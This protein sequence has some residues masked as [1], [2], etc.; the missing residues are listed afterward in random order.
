MAPAEGG[1]QRSEGAEGRST[2]QKVGQKVGKVLLLT[3]AGL[4]LVAV[5]GVAVLTNTPWGREQIRG[6]VL[7]QLDEVV[8]G[9]IEVGRLSGNLLRR[10][11]LRD[12]SLVD[13]QGRPF[14]EAEEVWIRYSITGLLRQRIILTGLHIENAR[15]V[16][17]DP[18]EEGWNFARIFLPDP[19]PDPEPEPG[20]GDWVELRE[21][22]IARTD[23]LIRMPWAPDQ[24][25]PQAE[26]EE[27]IRQALA[28]ETRERLVEVPGGYQ[29]IMEFRE[30]NA[31]LPRILVAH[32]D[33]ADTAVEVAELSVTALPFHPP[34]AEIRDL[35]GRI[36]VGEEAFLFEELRVELP[37][38]RIRA[39]GLFAFDYGQGRFEVEADPLELADLR[40]LHPPLPREMEGQARVAVTQAEALTRLRV[41]ELAFALEGGR[42]EGDLEVA[43]GETLQVDRTSLGFEGVP[44]RLLA[45]AL[46]EL[47]MP[48]HGELSGRV[49]TRGGGVSR[50]PGEADTPGTA[51]A[52]ELEEVWLEFADE[53]G[54]TSRA[55]AEGRIHLSMDPEEMGMQGLR[56][57]LDPLHTGIVR[58]FLP[59]AR[60]HGVIEALATLDG[61]VMGPFHLQGSLLHRDPVAGVSRAGA[62]GEVDLREEFRLSD[63]RIQLDEIQ[64]ELAREWMEPLPSGTTLSGAV[65]LDGVPARLLQVE[66]DLSVHDPAV[67][68]PGSGVSRFTVLG[69]ISAGEEVTLHS[70]EVTLA[71][72]E[73]ELL[74]G[75]V[76]DLPVAGTLEGTTVLDGSPGSGLAF[77]TELMH[78]E[79]DERSWVQGEGE[80]AMT[81]EGRV[82]VDLEIHELSLVTLGRFA[83]E[84]QLEGTM[85]G[86]L[87]ATGTLADLQVQADLEL[88]EE[89]ALQARGVLDL[90]GEAPVYELRLLLADLN[91][92]AL[93]RRMPEATSIGGTV[94]VDGRGTDPTSLQATLSV[95]LVDDEPSDPRLLHASARVEDALATL[96]SLRWR[97]GSSRLRVDGSFGLS[98]ARSGELHYQ[99]ALDSLHLLSPFLSLDPGTMEPRPAVLR[100]SL[101]EREAELLEAIREAEVEFLAT[102]REP[103]VPAPTDT[104]G[105]VGIQTDVL[106]GRMEASGRVEGN[107]EAFDL[108]GE[109]EVEELLAWGH[110]VGRA[111]LRYIVEGVGQDETTA[112]VEAEAATLLLAGFRY[113]GL[114]LSADY[115]GSDPPGADPVHAGSG[116]LS[117]EQ[118][119][120]T[121]IQAAAAF[122][123]ARER[124]QV[125]LEHLTL[126]FEEASWQLPHPAHLHW[127]GDGIRVEE[128]TLE[129]EGEAIL[130]VDGG[131]PVAEA[132]ALDIR[133]QEMEIAPLLILLQE[134]EGLQGRLSFEAPIR[135]TAGRPRFEGR[136]A[137]T[138]VELEGNGIPDA[139][140]RFTYLDREFTADLSMEAEGDPLLTLEAILPL[141]LSLVDAAE[142]RLLPDPIRIEARLHDLP[143][144]GFAAFSEELEDLQGTVAGH[145]TVGG[146]FEAPE[147]EGSVELVAPG[148]TIVPLGLRVRDI[149]GS[150]RLE[151]RVVTVDSL[152]AHSRGPIRVRGGL[153]VST[154]A[155]PAFDLVVEA[156]D[157]RVIYTADA[158]VRVDADLSVTGPFDGVL[159]EGR[160]RTRSGVVRIP[161]TREMAEPGPLDLQDPA[162]FERVDQI[163]VQA[164][165]AL[166]PPSP[167]VEELRVRLDLQIDRDFWV[168]SQEANVELHTLPAVGPL[169]VRMDG[170]AA[171][172][173][174]LEGTINTDRGE[175]E[176]MGRR[177]SI[178]RGAV[179]FTPGL[180]LDPLIRLTAE[181]EVQLPGR[182]AFDIRIIVD[183]TLLDLRTEFEST[184]QPPLSQTD[185]LSLMVFG[186]EAGSLL[187]Q[188]GSSLSGQ[189]SS[190][191]PLVGSVAARATQQFATVGVEA[192]LKE[193]ESETARALG[194]DVLHIQPTDTPAE[195]FTGRALD[196]L[197]GTEIEAGRYLT[198]RLFV[199]GQARPTFV[200]PGARMEYQTDTGYLWRATWRPRFL[201]ALPSL[202]PTEPDRASVLG[203]FLLREWRF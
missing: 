162:T 11:G 177:F 91:L 25:L 114:S 198:S 16:L 35:S 86:D 57:G 44:T 154:P 85:A 131:L 128:F 97:S 203:M 18:P 80:V 77:E 65:H 125:E 88:P 189:G 157:A 5:I 173:M 42:I 3:L 34:A 140:A 8:E 192:L 6:I 160:V 38:S 59:E 108:E 197:R 150:L 47:E 120:D 113:D 4:V 112:S 163:L 193:V 106:G 147:T 90:A 184:A 52:L 186:R 56:V 123:V 102:G 104:L 136:A 51:T 53:E 129:S 39:E 84:A 43:F 168:R 79:G 103:T 64:L 181:Q 99:V 122:H 187:Q 145:F 37:N 100:E 60:L 28:A 115:Q 110:H 178:S 73:V 1:A 13:D 61:P 94:G 180:E 127:S 22:R 167:L 17:D 135:G 144:D 75:V 69:G 14:L 105:I 126:D 48:I 165:D 101:N 92:A 116:S 32:P 21:V 66:G 117:V 202:A 121:R 24:A 175:Y 139:T 159:V 31:H 194:L 83:P 170:I 201:P 36:R 30:L 132:G 152:V 196:V 166:I 111:S 119:E 10:V 172:D 134:R 49:E 72:L 74:R 155:E 82:S 55:F 89:A 76:A 199:S 7:D 63:L 146:T 130:Q 41:E 95:D 142:P 50:G 164:R 68:D 182:E 67:P 107:V 143:L 124:Y 29:S 169:S 183:G 62:L 149:A 93:S 138:E 19:D 81:G 45:E 109:V 9:R 23:V 161:E 191:G 188:P 58:A 46:P 96:D 137:W 15:I 185:L 141:D 171:R 151:D 27:V 12:V 98:G 174:T 40:F 71:P 156:R 118:D 200:H 2:P 158:N 176:F 148:V 33:T 133:I 153:D 54:R 26:R 70:F 190:G 87:Q 78:G 20:W 195:I 179:T